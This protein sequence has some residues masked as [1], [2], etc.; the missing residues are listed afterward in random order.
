MPIATVDELVTTLIDNTKDL[1]ASG[2]SDDTQTE[3]QRTAANMVSVQ[4]E[5]TGDTTD[6]DVHLDARLNTDVDW[7]TDHFIAASTGNSANFSDMWQLDTED[8]VE[9]RV[10][11]VNQDGANTATSRVLVTRGAG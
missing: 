6:F 8:V 2:G 5:V 3:T 4:V 1:T 11:V 7:V 10:R 9:I